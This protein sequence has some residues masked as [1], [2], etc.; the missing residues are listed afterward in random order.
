M[1]NTSKYFNIDINLL[2]S[3]IKSIPFNQIHNI[4][5]IEWSKDEVDR[6]NEV[7][8]TNE[9]VYKALLESLLTSQATEI[10]S[11][12]EKVIK[13]IKDLKISPQKEDKKIVVEQQ[14]ATNN[15]ESME[16]WLDDVLDL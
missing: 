8:K 11:S 9:E 2:N 10:S 7:S 1:I 4:E 14:G 3:C 12:P 16:K 15:K 6:M 13:E 5:G